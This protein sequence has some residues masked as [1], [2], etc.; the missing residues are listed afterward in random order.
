MSESTST[1]R[2]A[3]SF[4]DDR[5]VAVKI[6][7]AV[8]VA[9][10]GGILVAGV[11]ISRTQTLRGDAEAIRDQGLESVSGVANL[12]RGF[13]Q[14]RL[15]SLADETLA[16]SDDSP[17][18]TSY[19]ASVAEVNGIIAGLRA[20]LHGQGQLAHLNEFDQ[21]WNEFT[22]VVGT[23]YLAL[24]RQKRM[25]EFLEMRDTTI[26]P[27]S[28]AAG[29][30]LDALVA[31]VR[32]DAD[33]RVATAV[34]AADTART[35]LIAVIV[36]ATIVSLLLTWLISRRI[37]RS[38]RRMGNVLAEIA[39]GDLTGT[40]A[41]T[42][43]DEVGRMAVSLNDATANLRALI[44]T[45]HGSSTSLSAAAEQMTGTSG[46]IAASAEESSA[47]AMVV[48]AAAEQVSANVQ[49][50]AAGSEEMGASIAEISQNAAAAARVAAQAVEVAAATTGTVSKLGA[51]STE[52]A[53]V[54]KVITS[55]AEQTNLLALNATIEAARAGEAGK[56][57][58]VVATEVKELAQET[59]RATE[60]ISR[61]VEAIQGDTAGA[62]E[63][64]A[65]ISA[66]IGRINDY[67][68]TI[69]SAVEEQSATTNE[70]NR[71][72][73]EAATGA[74][75]IAQNITGVATA[76][77]VTTTGVAESQQA[78][79]ELAR[80]SSDLQTAVSRFRY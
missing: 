4:F 43:R 36:V 2:S 69:A 71:N 18:H 11:G 29:A 51:S 16:T 50:V 27:I 56:G 30:S 31:E 42:S 35:T 79:A 6:A 7:S 70:M 19:L 15:D 32:A 66:I 33:K 62:V 1:G 75:E 10:L 74:G 49:T 64:I 80:M 37:T 45:I 25:T 38:L 28:K 67:Q 22:G 39:E 5:P 8:L 78:V 14:T 40:A 72:V 55:I 54:I 47:Q 68:L 23:R 73:A 77:E 52:I 41:V 48:S 12:R 20:G 59:A 3:W 13:L 58:A 24:A 17:E 60:D 44:G 21:H 9:L 53:D 65:E 46:Q 76:A 26:K 34:A 61:R 57:F 63:A